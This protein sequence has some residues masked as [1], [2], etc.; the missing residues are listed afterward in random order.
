[1]QETFFEQLSAHSLQITPYLYGRL[2]EPEN[3]DIGCGTNSAEVIQMLYQR[4]AQAHPEAGAVYWL[5]RTWDLLCWQPVSLAFIATYQCR[6]L[7][8]ITSISQQVVSTM[9]TGYRF[10]SA[11][12][13][14]GTTSELIQR[15]GQQLQR[16]LSNYREQMSEW[17]R[18][19]P[20]FTQHLLA[21]R[22]IAYVMQLHHRQPQLPAQ[23]LLE[24]AQ[25]WLAACALPEKHLSTLSIQRETQ[26]LCQVRA[27]CCLVYKCNG[28]ELCGNCPRHPD[29]RH[30]RIPLSLYPK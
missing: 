30:S 21:D 11:E 28:R 10:S 25:Q 24:Q 17:T 8:E 19:R 6:G 16:L 14:R 9:V 20:G 29:N 12:V 18:I 7:P 3:G 1:M 23:F 27:S 2:G 4:L 15:A 5:T 26:S 13:Y 22:L